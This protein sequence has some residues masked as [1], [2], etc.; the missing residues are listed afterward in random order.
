MVSVRGI[1]STRNDPQM[2]DESPGGAISITD[3]SFLLWF[4][5][6]GRIPKDFRQFLSEK[7]DI[8]HPIGVFWKQYCH[9]ITN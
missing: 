6:R 7:F 3:I 2:L 4:R 5:V 8:H 1:P 9:Q